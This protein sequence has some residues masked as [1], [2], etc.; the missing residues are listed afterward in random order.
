[1]NQNINGSY[2]KRISE[3]YL[4]KINLETMKDRED[5]VK[6]WRICSWTADQKV[7]S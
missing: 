1:M 5:P 7:C 2:R 4:N 6:D 3:V